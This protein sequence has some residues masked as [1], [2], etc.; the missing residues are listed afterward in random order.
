MKKLTQIEVLL[1]LLVINAELYGFK[2]GSWLA[3]MPESDPVRRLWESRLDLPGNIL[4]WGTL[5]SW[6]VFSI[7]YSILAFLHVSAWT[8]R[9]L[10]GEDDA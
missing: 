8:L 5:L 1:T 4:W 3:S 9:K 10:G 7:F 6:L 2:I